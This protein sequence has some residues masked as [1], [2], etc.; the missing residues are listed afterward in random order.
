MVLADRR[1]GRLDTSQTRAMLRTTRR[2]V[3]SWANL[4]AG[5]LPYETLAMPGE[6]SPILSWRAHQIGS[7]RWFGGTGFEAI[8]GGRD[9]LQVI[10]VPKFVLC[11]GDVGVG[12]L[13]IEVA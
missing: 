12:V 10:G 11:A 9:G 8:Q 13:L 1:A 3:R 2:V 5:F 7:S 6:T 4:S